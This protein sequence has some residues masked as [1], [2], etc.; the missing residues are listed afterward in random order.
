MLKG[1]PTKTQILLFGNFLSAIGNGLV[2]PYLFIYLHTIRHIPSGIAGVVVGYGA[3]ISLLSSPLVGTTID[4]FGPKPV[5]MLSLLVSGIG[6]ASLSL[7]RNIPTALMTMTIV[8]IGQSAMWPSQGAIG[9]EITPEEQRQQLFGANFALMNIGLGVGGLISSTIVS[10]TNPR[11][12]EYM[13]WCDG[14]SFIVYL[15]VVIFIRGVGHRSIEEREERREMSGGWREVF[16]DKRFIRFWLVMLCAIIFGY[17]QLEVGFASFASLVAHVPP[18]NIAYAYAGNTVLIGI[19]QMWMIRAT[20]N[21]SSNKGLALAAFFWMLSW[22][23]LS[24]SGVHHST[25]LLFIILCQMIFGVGEMVWS[26]LIPS[27]T[28]KLAPEHLR[29]RYNSA[30]SNAWQVALIMGPVI[31]GNLLGA[32]LHWLWIGILV[33]GLLGVIAVALRLKLPARV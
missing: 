24:L 1:L 9:V 17:S 16:A 7:V 25:A 28:N 33:G 5:L 8:S 18:S 15:V 32:G 12:F 26:P 4:H 21:L 27:I 14:S 3:L 11:S 30:T 31:A 19:G 13:Y 29:G 6:Y 23:T 22:I 20:K 10:L 2:L